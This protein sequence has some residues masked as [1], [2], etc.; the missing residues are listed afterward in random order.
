M[1]NFGRNHL[2]DTTDVAVMGNTMTIITKEMTTILIILLIYYKIK[3]LTEPA[4][5]M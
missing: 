5:V 1:I 3:R 4:S 2:E